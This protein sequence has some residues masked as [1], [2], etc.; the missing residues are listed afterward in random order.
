MSE[1]EKKIFEQTYEMPEVKESL[2]DVREGKVVDAKDVAP[3]DIIKALAK[4][5]SWDIKDPL[6]GCKKCYGRGYEGKNMDGS[7][8][9]CRCLFR[10]KT[11]EQ[12]KMELIAESAYQPLSKVGRKD[13]EKYIHSK[14]EAAKKANPNL[15]N[16]VKEEYIAS[17]MSASAALS[18]SGEAT[19]DTLSASN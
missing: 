13:L 4:K 19:G 17:M 12:K 2:V 1:E 5:F 6:S 14:V 18:A 3:I 16:E 10:G 9:P 8:K 15:I 11:P 7:P